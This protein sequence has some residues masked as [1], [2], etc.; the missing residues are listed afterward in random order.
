M[1]FTKEVHNKIYFIALILLAASMPLSVFMMSVSQIILLI[2]WILELNFKE[3]F[4]KLIT[5]KSIIIFFAVFFVHALGLIHTTDFNYAYNDLKVKVPLLILPLIIGTSNALN[6]KHLKYIFLAFSSAIL[7]GTLIG[8]YKY[9]GFGNSEISDVRQMSAFISHIRFSLMINMAIFSLIY[10]TIREKSRLLQILYIIVSIWFLA[11]LFIL[12]SFTGFVVFIVIGSFYAI[13]ILFKSNNKIVKISFLSMLFVII[14]SSTYY[15]IDII[16]DFYK[17][18]ELKFSQLDKISADGNYYNHDT[19]NLVI[20]N[21]NYIYI[22]ICNKELDKEW[23]NRGNINI[24]NRDSKG[25]QIRYTLIRYLSSL[26]LRKDADGVKKLTIEDIKAIEQG[27]TNYKYKNVSLE[28]KIYESIWEFDN[29]LKDQNPNGHSTAQRIE[30][31]KAG[32]EIVKRNLFFGVGTGDVQSEF[33]SQYELSNSKLNQ[34][35]R[36]RA[37]NQLLTF[38][39]AF[40]IIGFL[41]IIVALLL[42]VINEKTYKILLFNIFIIISI[43]SFINEDTLETQAGITFFVF[44]YTIFTFGFN[45]KSLS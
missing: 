21:G 24:N 23:L 40:G 20:E 3:K 19:L 1:I 39:I 38:I 45:S 36:L 7:I 17:V 42:P 10:F 13:Y 34:N 16:T 2:N 5:R 11:F 32:Y 37:H 4:Q 8:I 28:K 27:A 18:E 25:Q 29:I 14:L 26:G 43:L 6:F 35:N 15:V 33:N 44:F 9:L 30:F 31:F 22:Y 41:V 12:Q